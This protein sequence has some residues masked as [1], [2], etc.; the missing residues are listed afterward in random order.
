MS[1]ISNQY[2]V[3]SESVLSMYW[4]M[5]MILH[6]CPL[7]RGGILQT[8][9]QKCKTFAIS[10]DINFNVRKTVCMVFNP[11]K[12]YGVTHLSGSK[13][14]AIFLNG[15]RLVWVENFKYLW[16]VVASNLSD[17]RDMC[18][19]KQS[20][21]YTVN[22]ICASVCRTN[23]NNL[24]KLFTACCTIMYGFELWDTANGRKAFHDLCVAY[25]SCIKK[26]VRVPRWARNHDL[27]KELGLL[28][29]PMVLASRQL[30]FNQ[31]LLSSGN[32]MIRA[33]SE[34]EV[35]I[36]GMFA[37]TLCKSSNSMTS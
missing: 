31:R 26:L 11:Q 8:L 1:C 4:R 34:S 20:L 14:P 13:P 35:G 6:F 24:I 28:S 7:Q 29:G 10:R 37:K 33:M 2:A 18:R 22:M 9:I 27:C 12:P 19:V 23:R 3:L 16:H 21:Y 30:L 17:G 36:C 15:H 5:Q 25:H 32:S